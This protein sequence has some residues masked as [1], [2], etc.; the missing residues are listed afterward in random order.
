MSQQ[1]HKL[2]TWNRLALVVCMLIF[3]TLRLIALDQQYLLHDERDLSLTGYAIAHTGKD[4]MG[5]QFPLNFPDTNPNSPPFPYYFNALWWLIGIPLSVF[6]VRL[7]YVL[8]T[9]LLIPALY[10][11]VF[12]LTKKRSYAWC[13]TLV[14]ISSPWI[15]HI[16]RLGLDS[17][18]ALTLTLIAIALAIRRNT[19]TSLIFFFLAMNCYQ[20]F[21]IVVPLLMLSMPF[22]L[23]SQVDTKKNVRKFLSWFLAVFV[24]SAVILLL[25]ANTIYH[26]AGSELI[27][28]DIGSYSEQ[29]K[30]DRLAAGVDTAIGTLF[31]NKLT[32]MLNIVGQ[33]IADT[34]SLLFLFWSGDFSVTGSPFTGS[35]YFML[36]PVM[37]IGIVRSLWMNKR[38]LRLVLISLI[39]GSIPVIIHRGDSAVALRG[40]LMSI[41]FS[42]LISHGIITITEFIK[43]HRSLYRYAFYVVIGLCILINVS[44]SAFTYYMRRPPQITEFF[45]EKERQVAQKMI[46]P[47]ELHSVYSQNPQDVFLAYQLSLRQINF[48]EMPPLSLGFPQTFQVGDNHYIKCQGN[49]RDFMNVFKSIRIIERSCVDDLVAKVIEDKIGESNIVR[50]SDFSHLP[51]YYYIPAGVEIIVPQQS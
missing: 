26:R 14:F 50:T 32:I 16:T 23:E 9:S 4:F 3:I 7:P 33:R 37:L 39:I 48:S 36:L 30:S 18:L 42:I 20:A 21:R 2:F 22:I 27:F 47:E 34:T 45:F 5:V 41:G 17:P 6:T 46:S 15:F 35:F 24:F 38:L 51:V 40:S 19:K 1:I 12:Q 31:T 11:I 13:T 44:F 8:F 25:N 29:V 43:S 28:S 10:D 49:A